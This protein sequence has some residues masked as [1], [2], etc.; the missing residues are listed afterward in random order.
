M[1]RCGC[2]YN[3]AGELVKAC[4]AHRGTPWRAK[5]AEYR[6]A[7][8]GRKAGSGR[9][10]KGKGKTKSKGKGGNRKGKGSSN[11]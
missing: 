10:G 4:A 9:R 3:H 11:Y 7:R 1:A 8:K 2:G 5:Q 6:L